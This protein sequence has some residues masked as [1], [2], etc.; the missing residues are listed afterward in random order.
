MGQGLEPE[1]LPPPSLPGLTWRRL[2]GNDLPALVELSRSCVATDGG[3]PSLFEP[4]A[5]S[6]RYFPDEAGAQLGAFTR[7]GNLI[8]SAAVHLEEGSSAPRVIITGQVRPDHR[9]RGVGSYLV[10]WSGARGLAILISIPAAPGVLRIDAESLTGDADGL[11]RSRG[12]RRVDESL[13]MR[14]D[15]RTALPDP[16]FPAGTTVTEWRPELAQGFFQAYEPAFRDRPGFPGW[17]DI[18]WTNRVISNDLMSHWTLLAIE[19][20]TPLG[21]VIGCSD[22]STTP[23]SG[24][25]WQVGVIPQERRRGI[26]SALLV[27]CMRRMQAEVAPYVHLTVH[28][29]NPSA[30]RAYDRLGFEIVGRRAQYERAAV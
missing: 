15:L 7:D 16:S 29:D 14:R 25:V 12:F 17:N 6:E 10:D 9:R 8:A 4:E 3:L 21:Y 18:E 26:A 11:F 2:D 28:T 27:E 24:F 22:A 1:E 30:I 13:V 23:A 19:H 20:D 5:V